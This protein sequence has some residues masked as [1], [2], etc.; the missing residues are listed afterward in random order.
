MK[1]VIDRVLN[2]IVSENGLKKFLKNTIPTCIQGIDL[3]MN[4][5]IPGQVTVL[6]GFP[7]SYKT[8]LAL[9]IAFNISTCFDYSSLYFSVNESVEELIKRVLFQSTN[10]NLKLYPFKD[11]SIPQVQRLYAAGEKI[12]NSPLKF[13]YDK[14]LEIQH[15]AKI[16]GS[17]SR[18]G[19]VIVDYLQILKNVKLEDA[20]SKFK[21][22]SKENNVPFVVINQDTLST[23]EQV[24][25]KTIDTS[26]YLKNG[27]DNFLFLK[28]EIWHDV[29]D[30]D[31]VDEFGMAAVLEL[32]ILKQRDGAAQTV[33]LKFIENS[34][35][36]YNQQAEIFE[37]AHG[38]GDRIINC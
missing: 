18:L 33:H 20:L 22:I 38:Y 11:L 31:I 14:D 32:E 12:K 26:F 28:K 3:N 15:V 16:V 1:N 36:F 13:I 2:D 21:Q 25:L 34:M 5:L 27:V 6:S 24:D 8:A 29:E 35:R 10:E 23:K 9:S 4:G 7:S 37:D 19:V 17:T 30:E